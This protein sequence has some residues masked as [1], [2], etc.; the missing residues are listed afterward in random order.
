M[1]GMSL[2][3]FTRDVPSS[4]L[5]ALVMSVSWMAKKKSDDVV[6]GVLCSHAISVPFPPAD[7]LIETG[8]IPYILHT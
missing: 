1:Q 4:R 8:S 6:M 5:I 2:T 3:T 7:M